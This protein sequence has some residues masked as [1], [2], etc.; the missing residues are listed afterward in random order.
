VHLPGA[1]MNTVMVVP[2]YVL[3]TDMFTI[4]YVTMTQRPDIKNLIK[5]EEAR[6]PVIKFEMDDV[7]FDLA[8][9]RFKGLSQLPENF[10]VTADRHL[11]HVGDDAHSIASIDGV[12]V[13][14]AVCNLVPTMDPLK[15][16]IRAL[17]LWAKQRGVSKN[18]LGF[19]GGI[20]I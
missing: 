3:R 1:D 4:L 13:T 16:C 9:A 12:R 20:S 15:Y 14:D 6:V 7:E 11:K 2:K 10:D 19:L 18:V 8:I 5:V 17:K